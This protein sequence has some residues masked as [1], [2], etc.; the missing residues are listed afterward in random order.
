MKKLWLLSFICCISSQAAQANELARFHAD[1]LAAIQARYAG[2]PFILSL[3]SANWCGHCITELTM[4][5]K[6]AHTEKRLPLVLVSVDRPE[7]T[8]ALQATL[9]SLGLGRMEAWVFDDDISERL[10]AAVDPAWHG[11]L[12]RTY[13]YDA[14]HRREAVTGILGEEKLK[15]WLRQN[16]RD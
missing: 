11:E 8:P 1:S 6:L 3:W 16:V 13:L 12:P 4:L 10:R 9:R 5:G 2:Q 7:E 15:S 14:Q